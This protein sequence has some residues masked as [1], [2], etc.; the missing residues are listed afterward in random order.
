MGSLREKIFGEV[1][2]LSR[3]FGREGADLKT[4]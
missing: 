4:V 2:Q 1:I 3:W